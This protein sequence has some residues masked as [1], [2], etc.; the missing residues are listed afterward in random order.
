MQPACSGR[1][2]VHAAS[3]PY[4]TESY[5][6]SLMTMLPDAWKPPRATPLTGPGVGQQCILQMQCNF[7]I[8]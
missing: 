8:N 4:A 1:L 6:H 3:P 7:G 5:V 2:E